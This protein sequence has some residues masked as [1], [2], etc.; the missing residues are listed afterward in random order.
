MSKYY[1][2][3]CI[4]LNLWKKEV[5]K[6]ISLW[7][8][9]SDFFEKVEVTKGTIHYSGFILKELSF[10]LTEKEFKKQIKIFSQN[11]FKKTFLSRQEYELA[12]II[13]FETNFEISFFDIIHFL[14]AKKTN[15]ILITRDKK[16]VSIAKQYN[17]EIGKPEDFIEN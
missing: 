13:E 7:K 11:H 2:D 1:I 5:R 17:V 16:L 15:S 12:R 4:Y 3:T 6:G 8:Y 9:T 10:Q 14:L